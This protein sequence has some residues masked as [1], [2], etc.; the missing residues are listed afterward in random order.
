MKQTHKNVYCPGHCQ[1]ILYKTKVSMRE[2]RI[3]SYRNKLFLRIIKQSYL[4]V[5]GAGKR[6]VSENNAAN[7]A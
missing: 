1:S 4:I 6:Y 3:T 5:R 7:V 2:E